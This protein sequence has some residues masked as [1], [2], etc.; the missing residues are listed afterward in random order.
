MKKIILITLLLLTS[1]VFAEDHD[2]YVENYYRKI[3]LHYDKHKHPYLIIQNNANIVIY[4]KVPIILNG[5]SIDTVLLSDED[6]KYLSE[7]FLK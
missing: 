7:Q 4:S 1:N 3:A 2:E 6:F 5:K